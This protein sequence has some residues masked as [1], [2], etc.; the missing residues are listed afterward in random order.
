MVTELNSYELNG[1]KESI[2]DW[3]SNISPSDFP[4][5]SMIGKAST[6][7]PKFEWQTDSDEAVNDDNALMEGFE[8]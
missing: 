1:V 6:S 4:F 2:A 3:I 5:Q 8:F 7:Q